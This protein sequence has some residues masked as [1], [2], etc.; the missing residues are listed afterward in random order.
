MGGNRPKV[1]EF[2]FETERITFNDGNFA[3]QLSRR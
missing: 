1:F 2:E 3:T